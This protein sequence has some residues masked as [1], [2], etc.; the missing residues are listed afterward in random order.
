MVFL[1]PIDRLWAV[2]QS[3]ERVIGRL[4]VR[5]RVCVVDER[6]GR[7]SRILPIELVP[8]KSGVKGRGTIGACYPVIRCE[9]VRSWMACT[10]RTW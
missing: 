2:T 6:R 9:F 3:S 8:E 1:E 7:P 10:L 4:V 5:V